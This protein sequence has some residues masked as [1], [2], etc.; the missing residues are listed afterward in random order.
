MTNDTNSHDND[1]ILWQQ[2]APHLDLAVSALSETDRS[3]VLL[4]FYEKAPMRKVGERLG[5]SEDA[6]KK[7]VSRAVEKMREFL[8]KLGVKLGGVALAGVL[9]EK[10]VQAASGSDGG[11]GHQNCDGRHIGFDFRHAA[12]IGTGNSPRLALGKRQAGGGPRRLVARFDS[13]HRE[14]QFY[15]WFSY[16]LTIR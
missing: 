10:T 3:A 6:A 13:C 14:C 11:G 8:V 9:A 5:V 7:R 12:A 16:S 2:L 4:R 1:E 15:A